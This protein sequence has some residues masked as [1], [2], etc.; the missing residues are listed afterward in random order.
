[1]VRDQKHT[2][3][4]MY[5]VCYIRTILTKIRTLPNLGNDS[6]RES[7][8]NSIWRESPD[9]CRWTDTCDE[10]VTCHMLRHLTQAIQITTVIPC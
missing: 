4:L 2:K 6:K 5:S 3:V 1:M 9:M 8:Q 10:A 7:S